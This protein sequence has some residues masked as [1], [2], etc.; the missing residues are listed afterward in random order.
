MVRHYRKSGRASLTDAL[1]ARGTV[2]LGAVIVAAGSSTRMGGVDKVFADL[3]G[4]PVLAW[5]L[6][7]FESCPQ[8]A[9]SVVVV[10]A[11][12]LEQAQSLISERGLRKPVMFVTGGARRQDSVKAGLDALIRCGV[13]CE[14]VAVHD[15]ARPFV[16]RDM[17]ERGIEAAQVHGAAVAAVPVKD[18]IKS[19]DRNRAVAGTPDRRTLWAVQTPQVFQRDVILEA[20]RRVT[21]DVTDDASM[22]EALGGK[23]A[24]FEGHPENIKITTPDD[25][26][27]AELIAAKRAGEPGAV[28]VSGGMVSGPS[29]AQAPRNVDLS[30]RVGTGFDGHRLA[31][32]GPLRLGGV[33]IPHDQRLAGHSDGDVLLHAVASAFLG[34]AGLGDL[35]RHFPSSDP[36]LRGTDSRVLLRRVMDMVGARGWLPEYVDATIIAQRPKLAAHLDQMAAAISGSTGLARERVNVKVTSTDGVGAIGEG[37]G[38]A[39]QAIAMVRRAV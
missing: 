22:V 35:G 26:L 32:P 23:V 39:A 21:G 20:H 13:A 31:P 34:A 19:V 15:G 17:I 14:L 10:A 4:R 28:A 2:S 5:S 12:S 25:L 3:R 30:V 24:V 16:D 18:T 38:I 7:E 33:D 36:S 27:L 6:S 1:V 29:L 8:T 9:A 37:Q 11:K